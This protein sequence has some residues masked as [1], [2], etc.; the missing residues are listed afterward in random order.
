MP[1]TLAVTE[2]VFM[3]LGSLSVMNALAKDT[4]VVVGRTGNLLPMLFLPV[5]SGPFVGL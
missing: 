3:L 4:S 1:I 5:V 2:D